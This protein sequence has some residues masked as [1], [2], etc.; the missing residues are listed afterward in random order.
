M[1]ARSQSAAPVAAPELPG[2]PGRGVVRRRIDSRRRP[3]SAPGA[4]TPGRSTPDGGGLEPASEPDALEAIELI[5]AA[6]APGADLYALR[7]DGDAGR[8][9]DIQVGD[10]VVLRRTS[11]AQRGELVAVRPAAGG[12]IRI[13]RLPIAHDEPRARSAGP[14]EAMFLELSECVIEGSVVAV[15]RRAA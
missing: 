9:G 12:G 7:A 10:L 14:L 6:V 8:H 11:A 4:T 3:R 13:V 2:T 15:V 5:G 1:N